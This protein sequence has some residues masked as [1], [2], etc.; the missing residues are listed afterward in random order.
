MQQSSAP[1]DILVLSDHAGEAARFQKELA[2][3]GF[4]VDLQ[5]VLSI[6]DLKGAL[7]NGSFDLL[8]VDARWTE[9]IEEARNLAPGL[10]VM[11]FHN[12][13]EDQELAMRW[14]RD[15]ALD[16]FF[17][18]EPGPLTRA[19]YQALHCRRQRQALQR[20]HLETISAADML[21]SILTACPFGIC[22]VDEN[23]RVMIWTGEV[24]RM[25]GWTQEEVLGRVP[26]TIPPEGLQ[27][28]H[29]MVQRVVKGEGPAWRMEEALRLR[30]DGTAFTMAISNS[31]LYDQS[32]RVRGLVSTQIDLTQWGQFRDQT[33]AV[34][35][36]MEEVSRY[37]DLLEAAPD[38]IVEVDGTGR[39]ALANQGVQRLFGYDPRQLIGQSV[40]MLVPDRFKDTHSHRRRAYMDSPSIRP[41]GS[42]LKLAARR[43]DGREFP[44]E[45]TLSPMHLSGG[46]H[47]AAAIRDI[48]DREKLTAEAARN[49]EQARTLF[50][51]YPVPAFV[52]DSETF[53]FLAVNDKAAE[54]YGYP[55]SE[56]LQAT[57]LDVCPETLQNSARAGIRHVRKDGTTFEVD[58][59]VHDVVM[60]DRP[61]RMVVAYN[62]TE[63]RRREEELQDARLKAEAAS[64]AKSE[65]LASMSH[66]LRSPLHTITGFSELLEEEIEGPLNDKQKRFVQHIY[67]DSQHL[68]ALIN[69]ILDLSKIEAGRLE[70]RTEDFELYPAIEEVVG[71]IRPQAD[72]KSIAIVN[73]AQRDLM[74]RADRLRFKQII[75]NLLSNAVKFTPAGGHIGI[76]SAWIRKQIAITVSD[77]GIGIPAEHRRAIFDVFY[78]AGATTKGIREGTGLGLAICKRLVEQQNGKIWLESEPGRGSRFSFSLPS[79]QTPPPPSLRTGSRPVVLVVE[80]GDQALLHLAHDLEPDGYDVAF[81]TSARDAMVKA[82]ELQP[83]AI[84]LD[85][86][87]PGGKGWESL[88]SLKSLRDTEKIP[89]IAVSVMQGDSAPLGAA[90]YLAKPVAKEA[91]LRALQQHMTPGVKKP[92]IL[93]VDDEP[94]ALELTQ[95]ILQSAGFECLLA[96]NGRQALDCLAG[97]IPAAIV[98]DLMMPDM[99]GF[100]L[101]FR[102]KGD[103]RY[104][105]IPVLVLTGITLSDNEV[106]L[107]RRTTNALLIKGSGWKETLLHQLALLGGKKEPS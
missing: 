103:P 54:E 105:R 37:R 101:I 57:Y 31:P 66:E 78:Q 41:M 104:S 68:L 100:E 18:K 86:M 3:L 36:E 27:P 59:V 6:H 60:G 4:D 26:P 84:L 39:I 30:K 67:R 74:L 83:Q 85:L 22:A 96:S 107:L 75:M 52:Y 82:L 38:A 73:Q 24:E 15:G 72:A 51:A 87:L 14:I 50:A 45:I 80:D 43:A 20:E 90:A 88:E 65:F 44:V 94:A 19:A 47:V 62:V 81:A 99:N 58:E 76:E 1:L 13:P 12:G 40:D 55:R 10:P 53:R 29:N 91:L 49:A 71:T 21:H 48:T 97:R 89:I 2:A 93:A 5:E 56:F 61:A 70:F 106:I 46:T 11:A 64:R 34:R 92:T 77:T 42:G 33:A 7:Q 8:L 9:A 25:T 35:S 32:G 17:S 102:L 79:P 69:D 28:F 16:C 23:G 63:R 98:V 95:Q